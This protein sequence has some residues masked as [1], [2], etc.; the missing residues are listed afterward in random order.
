M[1]SSAGI[2]ACMAE[3]LTLPIDTAKVRMQVQVIGDG[4]AAAVGGVVARPP[5]FI[6]VLTQ[7]AKTEGVSA[8]WKG[9][10]AGLHRQFI[11]ATL[12]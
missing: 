10:P 12:R 6:P 7:M 2:A 3:I 1:A 11:Y 4:G 9:L 8:W 5:G